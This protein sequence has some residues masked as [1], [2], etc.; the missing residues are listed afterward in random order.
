[1]TDNESHHHFLGQ[2]LVAQGVIT[3][4]QLTLALAKQKA[5]LNAGRCVPIGKMLVAME[6]A[7]WEAVEPVARQLET[8]RADQER[9]RSAG[10]ENLGEVLQ[11]ATGMLSISAALAPLIPLLSPL[12]VRLP[13]WTL[14]MRPMF[15]SSVLIFFYGLLA[16]GAAGTSLGDLAGEQGL[17]FRRLCIPVRRSLSLCLIFYT[18]FL[19]LVIHFL[20]ILLFVV[21]DPV[22]T[23]F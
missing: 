12:V 17:T 5:F 8:D 14:S 9:Q 6:L 22:I 4:E 2:Y 15:L 23:G 16:A 19:L 20:V 7:A 13:A 10:R 18:T 3:E 21:S 1:M 11:S